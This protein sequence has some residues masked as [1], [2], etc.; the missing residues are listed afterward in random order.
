MLVDCSC[1]GSKECDICGKGKTNPGTFEIKRCPVKFVSDSST[2]R[3]LPY[4]WHWKATN[5]MQYPD[6]KGRYE[7]PSK[8]LEAFSICAY[9]SSKREQIDLENANKLRDK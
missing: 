7:Q 8:L 1:G 3:M 2:N 4:F 9:I 5:N 6:G